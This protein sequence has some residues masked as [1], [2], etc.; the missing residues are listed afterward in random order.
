MKIQ[1]KDVDL[2]DLTIN[3]SNSPFP[4]KSQY[5][6]F[7]RIERYKLLAKGCNEYKISSLFV[8]HHLNDQLETLIMRLSR[9]SG[10]NGLASMS[11]ISKFPV[12]RNI[13]AI[14]LQIVRPLL[15]VTKVLL[16]KSYCFFHFFLIE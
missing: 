14:G 15:F 10:I 5:E 4:T 12:I 16:I 2:S 8:G 11:I 13:E 1:W 9:G 3:N 6:T 7:A